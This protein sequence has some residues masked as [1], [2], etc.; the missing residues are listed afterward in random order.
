MTLEKKQQTSA[1]FR[2]FWHTQP[3]ERLGV[4]APM[5]SDG[6]SGL[7][8]QDEGDSSGHNESYPCG[9]PSSSAAV[10]SSFDTASAK[11]AKRWA[12]GYRA[13]NLPA[14]LAPAFI[15]RPISA[16]R[17]A[18]HWSTASRK[19]WWGSCIRHFA[20]NNQGTDGW[21]ATP[22]MMDERTLH[23]IYLPA[24]E[25]VVKRHSRWA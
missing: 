5:M 24:F 17:W 14:L 9:L 19:Q 12:T 10:A 25:T 15:G 23:E 13:E 21:S 3:V 4:P 16:V 1:R 2:I 6:P 18:R 11:K 7:R 22:K 20:A 8:K